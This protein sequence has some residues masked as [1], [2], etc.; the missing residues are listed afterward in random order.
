V[1]NF[2]GKVRNTSQHIITL[3]SANASDGRS[4]GMCAKCEIDTF[5][6]LRLMWVCDCI[7]RGDRSFVAVKSISPALWKV[8]RHYWRSGLYETRRKYPD[9]TQSDTNVAEFKRGEC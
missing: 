9:R 5:R 2:V 3:Q 4:L 7:Y 1:Q 6:S 8:T